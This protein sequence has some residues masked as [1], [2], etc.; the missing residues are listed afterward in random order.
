MIYVMLFM[1][2]Y[3]CASYNSAF[4]LYWVIGNVYAIVEQLGMNKYF[5]TQELKAAKAEEVGIL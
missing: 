2:L 3:C 5:K 4:A 1:S